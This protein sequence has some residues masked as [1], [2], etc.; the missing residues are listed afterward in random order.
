M[1]PHRETMENNFF[2]DEGAKQ[3]FQHLK[4]AMVSLPILALPNFGKPFVVELDA[5]EQGLGEVLMQDHKPIAYFNH[6]LNQS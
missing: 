1:A 2:W 6:A 4:A 5:S 3:A